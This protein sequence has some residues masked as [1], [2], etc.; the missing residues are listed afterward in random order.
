M[1]EALWPYLVVLLAG[2]VPNEVF[3]LAAVV[4]GRGIDERSELFVWIRIVA[5]ALLA[6][7]VSKILYATPPV[8][9]AVP[10]AWRIAAVAVGV[11]A[12][13]VARR[14]LALGILAGE[15]VVIAAA[16]WFGPH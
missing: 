10:T 7:V 15:S 8:L 5:L 9:V 13:F 16:W 6:A 3:R 14:S 2:F 4:L 1:S 12:F 11:V